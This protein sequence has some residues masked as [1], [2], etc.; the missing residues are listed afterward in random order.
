MSWRT[1]SCSVLRLT[2]HHSMYP[3]RAG[4]LSLQ[5]WQQVRAPAA[6]WD[7]THIT[8][9]LAAK[10]GCLGSSQYQGTSQ[11]QEAKSERLH[12]AQGPAKIALSV[13]ESRDRISDNALGKHECLQLVEAS[14]AQ[15]L[16]RL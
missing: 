6:A 13:N 15:V 2:D 1:G 14:R 16:Q 11:H 3:E 4:L 8:S 10:C 9:V 12:V 7:R 5:L